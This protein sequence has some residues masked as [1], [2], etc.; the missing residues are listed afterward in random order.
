VVEDKEVVFNSFFIGDSPFYKKENRNQVFFTL[1]T[2]VDSLDTNNYVPDQSL[3]SSRNH[4]DYGGE[5]TII[6]KNNKIDHVAFT[7]LD[8][9]SFAIVIMRL[10]HLEHGNII[11]VIPQKDAS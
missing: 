5:G 9:G 4:F 6:T 2:V 11:V 7:T 1:I 8:K 10:F 3:F